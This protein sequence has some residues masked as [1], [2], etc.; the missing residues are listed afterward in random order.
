M[1]ILP[2]SRSGGSVGLAPLDTAA[3]AKYGSSVAPSIGEGTLT[4]PSRQIGL[5]VVDGIE[6]V[7]GADHD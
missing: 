5:P 7:R 3:G 2:L 1:G 6:G 4:S